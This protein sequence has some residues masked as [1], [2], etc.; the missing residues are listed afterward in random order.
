VQG[1]DWA[2]TCAHGKRQ[3]P[4][5]IRSRKAHD[6]CVRD[7]VAVQ[8]VR[9]FGQGRV[10]QFEVGEFDAA[11]GCPRLQR[12]ADRLERFGPARVACAVREQ[13]QRHRC[14]RVFRRGDAWGARVSAQL[15]FIFLLFRF[16]LVKPTKVLNGGGLP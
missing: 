3:S 5:T 8:C 16:N 13:H 9:G 7:A 4:I 12:G 6:E 14:R 1:D 2:G 10:H 11:A 15:F